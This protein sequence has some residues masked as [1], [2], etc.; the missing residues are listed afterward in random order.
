MARFLYIAA[1][2]QSRATALGCGWMAS[3]PPEFANI[4]QA[5]CAIVAGAGTA[6]VLREPTTAQAVAS[7]AAPILA[8]EAAA[9]N[10]A[11]QQAANA[12]T[13][14]VSAVNALA[15]NVNFLAIAS[16]STAQVTAQV[17]ALTRQVDALIRLVGGQLDS[18][19]GT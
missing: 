14:R 17:K 6:T 16:P 8:A 9:N 4:A 1:N 13:M 15:A 2:G 7:A 11:A 10:V 19:A 18:T 12:E 3:V 5:P